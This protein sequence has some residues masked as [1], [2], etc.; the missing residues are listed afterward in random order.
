MSFQIVTELPDTT[1]PSPGGEASV[2]LVKDTPVQLLDRMVLKLFPGSTIRIADDS[3]Q[4][5]I[6]AW[7]GAAAGNPI[8]AEYRIPPI[9][10][11]SRVPSSSPDR[12]QVTI[13]TSSGTQII[14]IMLNT[15]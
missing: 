5:I 9:T 3:D 6:R 1:P 10:T 13:E 15:A 12:Y 8:E 7:G 11:I 4:D 2:T 14:E